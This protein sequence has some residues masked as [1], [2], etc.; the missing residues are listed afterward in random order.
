MT[1][2]RIL[3]V[4]LL[5]TCLGPH[6]VLAAQERHAV[7]IGGIGGTPE[8][9]DRFRQYL[10]DARQALVGPLGFDEELVVV[11]AEG[12]LAKEAF[13]STVSTSENI[14]AHFE[15][16]AG[17]LSLDDHVFVLLFGHGSYDGRAARFNIPRRDLDATHYA[18]L[19]E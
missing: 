18:E 7:L 2:S 16:L 6:Q 10:Y 4:S 3:A 12:A 1:G 14:R 13:V 19:L 17:E 8:Q 11:L 5:A 15:T 9:T